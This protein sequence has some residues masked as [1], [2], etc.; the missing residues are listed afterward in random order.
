[1]NL[2]AAGSEVCGSDGEV[3]AAVQEKE[4]VG[5]LR[6]RFLRREKESLELGRDNGVGGMN[7]GLSEGIEEKNDEEEEVAGEFIV[8]A[9]VEREK[10]R[11]VGKMAEKQREGRRRL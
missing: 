5:F 6:W 8:G 9:L 3:G 11:K 7:E 1:M 4:E 10:P 2:E